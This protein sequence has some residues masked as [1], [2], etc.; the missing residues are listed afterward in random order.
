MNLEKGRKELCTVRKGSPEPDIWSEEISH[1][2]IW[3]RIYTSDRSPSIAD[4][5][6]QENWSA[7][8][9]C[10]TIAMLVT[11][12]ICLSLSNQTPQKK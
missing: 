1:I 4:N 10:S 3:S 7:N 8:L 5:I 12:I 11:H 9:G 2:L 6:W